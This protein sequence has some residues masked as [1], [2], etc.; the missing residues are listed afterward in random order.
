MLSQPVDQFDFE[1]H[2]VT[3]SCKFCSSEIKQKYCVSNGQYCL[4]EEENGRQQL[5]E[6]LTQVCILQEIGA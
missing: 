2:I 1:L 4:I 5:I 3:S 6:S